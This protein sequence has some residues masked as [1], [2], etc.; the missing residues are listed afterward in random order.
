MCI[1]DRLSPYELLTI[2][3]R[4][5]GRADAEIDALLALARQVLAISPDAGDAPTAP[6]SPPNP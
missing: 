4:L 2:H 5:K 3:W 1:R 6:A